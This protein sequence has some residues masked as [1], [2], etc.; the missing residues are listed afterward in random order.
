MDAPAEVR[1][2]VALVVV[3]V[4][5][6]ASCCRHTRR[7]F[8]V[9]CLAGLLTRGSRRSSPLPAAK[10]A[11]VGSER[12]L[13]AYSR[14]GGRGWGLLMDRP[15]PFPFDPRRFAPCEEPDASLVRGLVARVNHC[16]ANDAAVSAVLDRKPHIGHQAFGADI[17]QPLA[18]Q[19]KGRRLVDAQG[20]NIGRI[21]I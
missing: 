10:G 16:A 4:V 13:T 11:T 15:S 12:A 18:I 20:F 5:I 3:C 21:L 7:R 8:K 19:E 17:D 2:L 9:S 14:G 1:E 6:S